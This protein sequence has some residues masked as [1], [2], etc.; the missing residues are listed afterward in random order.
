MTQKDDN[1]KPDVSGADSAFLFNMIWKFHLL[2]DAVRRLVKA[3]G[4]ALKAGLI[5]WA[6]SGRPATF[7]MIEILVN[8]TEIR[9]LMDDVMALRESVLELSYEAERS[10]GSLPPDVQRS[11]GDL[12][13][14]SKLED[15]QIPCF[16]CW[17]TPCTC[18]DKKLEELN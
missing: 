18:A 13:H 7:P 6:K 14:V 11:L 12:A 8:P 1:Q 4:P 16:A 10:Y 17:S 5:L 3:G 2:D 9:A 15:I